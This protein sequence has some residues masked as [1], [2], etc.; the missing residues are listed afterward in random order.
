MTQP[1]AFAAR[2]LDPDAFE[3]ALA[4]ARG[5]GVH[6]IYLGNFLSRARATGG[7]GGEV[8]AFHGA[9]RLLGLAFF[10]T[11]GNLI[12][13]EDEP[14]DGSAVA[15]AVS[16]SSWSWRIALA[17]APAIEALVKLEPRPPLVHREQLYYGVRPEDVPSEQLRDDVREAERRDLSALLAAALDLNEVDLHV[18]R[19]RVHKPWLRDSIRRRVRQRQ[20]QVIGPP[21]KLLSKL[22]VG[23]DGPFGIVLEGVYTTPQAR[24]RGL[25]AGLVATAASRA[26]DAAP[27]VS[28]H[29]AAD[30]VPARRAYERAGMQVMQS[31]ELLL[32]L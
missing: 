31:C 7:E 10:G 1:P 23:S 28:L 27:L 18:D 13:V 21:G 26:G 15:R 24:G 20:T 3:A 22:D 32:R 4:L 6:G 25:A 14:L 11:R 5:A 9:E 8:L 30:N 29:V 17:S 12:V 2:P 19:R 16:S